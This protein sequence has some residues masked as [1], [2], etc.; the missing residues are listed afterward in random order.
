MGE[1]SSS[2]TPIQSYTRKCISV[3]L[4]GLL[5]YAHS[6]AQCMPRPSTRSSNPQLMSLENTMAGARLLK[7]DPHT[8]SNTQANAEKCIL[9]TKENVKRTSPGLGERNTPL[10][11]AKCAE[12]SPAIVTS[13]GEHHTDA[14]D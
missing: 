9:T 10:P 1:H 11:C 5:R 8:R 14:C 12:K 7:V 3:T 2:V 6:C 13:A 4:L